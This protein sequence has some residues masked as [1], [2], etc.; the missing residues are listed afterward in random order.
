MPAKADTFSVR[1]P[2][3]TR[4]KV[5]EIA[6]R[7]RRSRSFIVKEAVEQYV[8]DQGRYLGELDAAFASIETEGGHSADS[9]F[10]WMRSWG[11][12]GELPAPEID[13]PP[14]K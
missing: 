3:E 5:D 8:R 1:L 6:H 7:L 12:D 14:L 2:E 13:V 9:V 11:T 4:Q 10:R